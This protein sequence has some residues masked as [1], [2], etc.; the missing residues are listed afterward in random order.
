MFDFSISF[1]SIFVIRSYTENLFTLSQRVNP[2]EANTMA[3]IVFTMCHVV[4]SLRLPSSRECNFRD[5]PLLHGKLFTIPIVRKLPL[6]FA[7][8][9]F[10]MRFS[11]PSI[12]SRV[13]TLSRVVSQMV[14]MSG[15]DSLAQDV[16]A[17]FQRIKCSHLLLIPKKTIRK[18]SC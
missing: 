15:A 4:K 1:R 18:V 14:N 9:Q 10:S 17:M 5:N 7:I 16:F 3:H 11:S 2:S 12:S 6:S 13:V 8:R